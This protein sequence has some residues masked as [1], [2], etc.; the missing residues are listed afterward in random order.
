MD[1]LAA[2]QGRAVPGAMRFP[3]ARP[4]PS[5]LLARLVCLCYNGATCGGQSYAVDAAQI[6]QAWRL[7]AISCAATRTRKARMRLLVLVLK[8]MAYGVTHIAPGLGGGLVLILLGIYEEFVETVGNF[9]IQPRKWKQ[10]LAFLLPLGFG[11]VIGMVVA[12]W[13]SFG[14]INSTA[15]YD[16]NKILGLFFTSLLF[17]YLAVKF[18]LLYQL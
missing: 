12:T 3:C 1:A 14:L 9:F 2:G 8:G 5:W 17:L 15:N 7:A 16:I 6:Q 13:H 4:K 11:M 18:S 10:H